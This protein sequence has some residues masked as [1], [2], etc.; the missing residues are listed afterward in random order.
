[1]QNNIGKNV[2]R[3]VKTSIMAKVPKKLNNSKG[4]ANDI[5]MLEASKLPAIF[6]VM[7]PVIC[8][9]TSNKYV[10]R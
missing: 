1:M 8:K 9:I 4:G 10:A 7:A 3:P 6:R 5:N 2:T